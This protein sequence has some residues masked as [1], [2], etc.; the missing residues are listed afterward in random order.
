M[1]AEDGSF[2]VMH[3]SPLTAGQTIVVIQRTVPKITKNSFV[4]LA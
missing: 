4:R 3:K 1:L 2:L